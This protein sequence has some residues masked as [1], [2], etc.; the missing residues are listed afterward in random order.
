MFWEW[1][2]R[3]TRF[4]IFLEDGLSYIVVQVTYWTNEDGM[5]RTETFPL[6]WSRDGFFQTETGFIIPTKTSHELD[7]KLLSWR[8]TP[9]IFPHP[10]LLLRSCSF[11][12]GRQLTD[13]ITLA[14]HF[15]SHGKELIELRREAS[16]L[17]EGREGFH[18]EGNWLK[19][20][21]GP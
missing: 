4:L 5:G 14:S 21:V 7:S 2:R 11:Y 12:I 18:S 9:F 3:L 17:R 6:L 16:E 20:W 1:G 15:C 10:T 19:I 8:K 13:C